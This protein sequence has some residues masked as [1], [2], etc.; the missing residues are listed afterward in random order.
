[1]TRVRQRSRRAF[2][3]AAG[4]GA[5]TGEQ[6]SAADVKEIWMG[7]QRHRR[8]PVRSD[9]V[10]YWELMRL[11]ETLES[12]IE[13]E[14][15]EAGPG[16]AAWEAES[17]SRRGQ[18]RRL[19]RLN[20]RFGL[21]PHEVDDGRVYLTMRA[22][23]KQVSDG[24]LRAAILTGVLENGWTTLYFYRGRMAIDSHLSKRAR[25]MMM[26]LTQPGMP[27]A[28][29]A[30]EVSNRPMAAVEPWNCGAL[31]GVW[32]QSVKELGE[33]RDDLLGSFKRAK[34]RGLSALALRLRLSSPVSAD[35]GDAPG[36][37]GP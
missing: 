23:A 4:Q 18:R 13:H 7:G 24:Q 15:A 32:C 28:G 10:R 27:L 22:R 3:D 20:E 29:M 19:A 31:R 8:A 21:V 33:R 14:E 12:T 34:D 11:I 25:E 6:G 5:A 37:S 16:S 35:E 9:E 2:K 1:M 36:Q 30:I 17:A 26:E